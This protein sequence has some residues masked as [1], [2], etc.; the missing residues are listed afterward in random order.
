MILHWRVGVTA[1][2]GRPL[3]ATRRSTELV[4]RHPPTLN[5]WTNDQPTTNDRTQWCFML[6][7]GFI[8]ARIGGPQ[9]SS[10]YMQTPPSSGVLVKCKWLPVKTRLRNDLLCIEGV[11]R[12]VGFTPMWE[13]TICGIRAGEL[14]ISPVRGIDNT[15]TRLH[16][17]G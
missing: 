14:D 5:K 3:L 1:S 15:H 10:P 12:Y 13:R 7:V 17:Y 8:I 6:D 4:L 16:S 2:Y 11:G 9:S